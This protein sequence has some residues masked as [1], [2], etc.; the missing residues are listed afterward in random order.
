MEEVP[1]KIIVC[2]RYDRCDHHN[3]WMCDY[4]IKNLNRPQTSDY[5][6]PRRSNIVGA[7]WDDFGEK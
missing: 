6:E 1:D 5:F 2:H 7:D 4:C 3:T